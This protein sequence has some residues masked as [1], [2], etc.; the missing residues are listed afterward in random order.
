VKATVSYADGASEELVFKNGVEFADFVAK[1]DVPG[2]REVPDVM[3]GGQ[4]RWFSKALK[5][6]GTISKIALESFDNAVA[7]VLVAITTE[8][9]SNPPKDVPAAAPAAPSTTAAAA[10]GTNAPAKELHITA[11]TVIVGG[12]SSHNFDRW[13]NKEDTATLAKAF[14][15]VQYTDQ[16]NLLGPYVDKLDV[17]YLSN[18]QPITDKTVREGIMNRANSGKGLLLV[19]PALWYNWADWPEYNQKLV[20]GGARSHDKFGEFEVI[21]EDA[22]H[23]IM[24][25]VPATFNITDEL[26]HF[27]KDLSGPKIKVLATGRNKDGKAYPVVWITE[28]PNSKIV[29]ITL[30]HDDKSHLLPAFQTIL[31]NAHNWAKT[32]K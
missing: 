2:S 14:V 26:Y 24:K 15:N 29:C 19:H 20:G 17:L 28:L 30:G 12:G 9:S 8:Q 31:V 10:A 4:V 21:V 3:R 11:S 27:Q 16:P 13:F 22:D 23:P 6:N 18:N 7:P 5:M 25:G 1:Y 32:A